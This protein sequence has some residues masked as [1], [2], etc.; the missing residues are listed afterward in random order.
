[1]AVENSEARADAAKLGSTTASRI[2]IA[3]LAACAAALAACSAPDPGVEYLY[4]DGERSY[5]MSGDASAR[6]PASA[7]RSPG[8]DAGPITTTEGGAP[9]AGV[10]TNA[11]PFDPAAPAQP[12]QSAT[13]RHAGQQGAPQAPGS[14]DACLNCHTTGGTA[15]A[16]AFGGTVVSGGQP[17]A[18]AEIRVVNANGIEVGRA[19]SGAD[20]NF[21]LVGGGNRTIAAGALTGVRNATKVMLMAGPIGDGNCN[22][23]GACHGG[24][25]GAIRLD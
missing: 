9:S 13:Q 24:T 6:A 15:P 7:S 11:T 14:R 12:A 8:N 1:M 5:T 20:G 18:N 17:L 16:F 22:A 4:I 23:G 3:A 2:R 10:F 25:Q 21:W 19:K